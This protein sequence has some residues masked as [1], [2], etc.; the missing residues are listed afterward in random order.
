H[1]WTPPVGVVSA[2]LDRDTGLPATATTAPEKRYTEWF[3]A[4]TEP[5]AIAIDI[6]K[7]MEL[8]GIGR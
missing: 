3:V 4:G 6:W 8:G 5:G 1:P 7:L 2:E